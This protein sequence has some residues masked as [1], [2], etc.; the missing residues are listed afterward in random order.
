MVYNWFDKLN[1]GSPE[2]NHNVKDYVFNEIDNWKHLELDEN[3]KKVIDFYLSNE[4]Q[5][6]IIK[7]KTGQIFGDYM[8]ICPTYFMSRDMMLSN[9]GDNQIYLY[10]I[11]HLAYQSVFNIFPHE[12]WMGITHGA[13][14]EFF[15]LDFH[16]N[17]TKY[18][19]NKIINFH[20]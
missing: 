13:E 10:K 9:L 7:S 5:V 17:T 11:T 16:S 4:T 2:F 15:F 18:I 12:K 8:L 19:L 6:D 14:M 1:P 3:R 20:C